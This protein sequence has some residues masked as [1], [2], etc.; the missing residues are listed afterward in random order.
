[1]SDKITA[2]HREKA[3]YVYVRQSTTYQLQHNHESRRRQYELGSRA[4]ELGFARVVVIDDDLGISASGAADRPGFGRLL[5]AV[6]DGTVG[7]VLSIEASRLARNN[8]DWHHLIDLCALTST[9]VIDH[10]GVYDPRILNDRLLLGLKGTMSEFELGLLQQRS[11]EALQQMI[12]RGEVLFEMPIGYVRTR[13]NRCEQSPDLRVQEAIRGVFR[14]FL[15]L[16]SARQVLLWYRQEGVLMPSAVRGSGGTSVTWR[17]PIYR[18][19]HNILTN[20]TYAG[21][22]TYGRR[23][24]KTRVVAGRARKTS[25][26]RVPQD[27]WRVLIRDHHPGYISWDEFEANQKRITSNVAMRGAVTAGAAK[28]G[29]ALLAGLLRCGRCGRKLH[30]AYVSGRRSRYHCRGAMLNHGTDSCISFGGQK[31]EQAVADVFLEAVRPAGVQAS[32]AA[33]EQ[34]STAIDEKRRALELARQKAEYEVMHARRQ[35]DAVDPANRLVA[36]ELERRWNDALKELADTEGRLAAQAAS[37]K[38]V[39]GRVR[40]TLMALGDDVDSAW[41]HPAAP[42]ELKKRLL[43]SVIKEIVCNVLDAPRD[44]VL[45]VHWAGGVHSI[46]RVARPLPGEHN[47]RTDH[48]A[49]ELIRKLAEVCPDKFIAS[50][51]N[52]IGLKTG[53]GRTWTESYVQSHR[54]D[55]GI[56]PFDPSAPRNWLTMHE[57]A[58]AL[59]VSDRVV[60]RLILEKRLAAEQIV[61]KA[62]WMIARKDLEAENVQVV[63]RAIREGRR[64][65]CA[66]NAQP[67]LPFFTGDCEL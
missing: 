1:M 51:L 60:R 42:V 37:R 16:G 63:A 31:V 20:P 50:I 24:S 17:L 36:A 49:V 14:K 13:A 26:H 46:V 29:P 54:R 4:K 58:T 57:A 28:R 61:T 44:I 34:A 32:L 41:N 48:K 19:I 22:F 18:T 3:A 9:V 47:H 67:G 66:D 2:L 5:A 43:R 62:P 6:C 12:S 59:G 8:R 23:Q 52:R 15:E 38:P 45:N 7:A 33:W 21:A 56:A 39:D 53:N 10:D 11:R 65:P 30:V 40:E 64:A 55:R 35:Y 25:G 27:Q